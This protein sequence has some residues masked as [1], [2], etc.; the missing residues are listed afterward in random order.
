M[1][2]KGGK[3]M[4]ILVT[5]RVCSIPVF[6]VLYFEK[7]FQFLVLWNDRNDRKQLEGRNNRKVGTI[8]ITMERF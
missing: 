3:K 6:S 8:K 7:V 1:R 4:K 2:I 5:I